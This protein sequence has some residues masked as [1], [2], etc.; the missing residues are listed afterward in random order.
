M[1]SSAFSHALFPREVPQGDIKGATD[2]SDDD[3]VDQIDPSD[4]RVLAYILPVVK[5]VPLSPRPSRED[6]EVLEFFQENTG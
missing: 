4:K 3:P 6:L 5:R 2:I 1:M